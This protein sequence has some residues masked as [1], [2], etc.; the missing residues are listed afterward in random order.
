MKFINDINI[1]LAWKVDVEEIFDSLADKL[2][3]EWGVYAHFAFAN[4]WERGVL[5]KRFVSKDAAID[6]KRKVQRS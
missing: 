4:S 6:F 5:I 3:G 1:D 2:T